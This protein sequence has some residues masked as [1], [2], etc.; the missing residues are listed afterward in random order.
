MDPQ[1]NPKALFA[2]NYGVYIL[3]SVFEGKKNGQI[4]NALMQ[5]SSDPIC[6]AACLHKENYTTEL[7][8]KSGFFSVSVLDESVPLKFIGTFGFRCGRDIDKFSNCEFQV[9]EAG[10]PLVTEY[11][12]AGIELKVLSVH[13]MFT[14]KL[15]IAKVERAQVLRE[16]TPLSYANYH[17]IKKGKSPANAPSSVFNA[18]K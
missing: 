18:I 11:A 16:G 9:N 10:L 6:M 5:L 17:Q 7:V 2:L 12:L 8:E 14:H 3:S 13:D 15:F 4:I 1:I